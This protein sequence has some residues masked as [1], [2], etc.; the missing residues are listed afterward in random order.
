VRGLRAE[1]FT[2]D[3]YYYYCVYVGLVVL[4]VKAEPLASVVCQQYC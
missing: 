2:Q 3:G 1:T 4:F